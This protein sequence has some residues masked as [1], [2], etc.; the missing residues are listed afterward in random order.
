MT[1]VLGAGEPSLTGVVGAGEPMTGDSAT[2][3]QVST[4]GGV[5]SLCKIQSRKEENNCMRNGRQVRQS[6]NS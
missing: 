6:G 1:G 4:G 3:G 5:S 2:M